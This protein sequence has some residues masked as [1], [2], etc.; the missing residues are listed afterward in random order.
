MWGDSAN[1]CTTITLC[2]GSCNLA[3]N[4]I[5]IALILAI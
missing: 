3:S 1:H 5:A 4:A 2:Q